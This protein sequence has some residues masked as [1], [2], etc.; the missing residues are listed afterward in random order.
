MLLRLSSVTRSFYEAI[1]LTPAELFDLVQSTYKP[2]LKGKGVIESDTQERGAP[3][4]SRQGTLD[5]E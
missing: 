3:D 4:Y 1:W 2:L 5:L